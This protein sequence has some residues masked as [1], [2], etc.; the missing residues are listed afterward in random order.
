ME[1]RFAPLF[2]GS[3]GNSIYVGTDRTNLLIDAGVSGTRVLEE[4]KKIG[5]NP[6]DLDG[7]LVTHEHSDHI[8][9][10]GILARKLGVP[11]Y[12]TDGTWA[13]MEDKIGKIPLKQQ[14][15]ID[16]E[17]PFYLGDLDVTAFPTPHD[18]M[19]PC[20]FT[21]SS[22]SARFSV[23][24]DIGYA[25]EGWMKYVVGSDAVLLESNYDPDMLT[26]GPYPFELKKRILSRKGHLSN[27]DAGAVTA[28][29]V[30]AGARQVILGH[31]SRENNFPELAYRTVELILRQNG[32]APGDDVDLRTASRDCA[33]GLFALSAEMD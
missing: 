33:T 10:V 29:L 24:T 25:R 13:G 27:D 20:G 14:A 23:A 26:A 32:I 12:A 7:I 11:V 3:S 19:E 18:A 6:A 28:K 22:G 16:L 15:I 8:K 31:L 4:L 2:S 1:L 21:F 5:V 17:S 30:A 9:G